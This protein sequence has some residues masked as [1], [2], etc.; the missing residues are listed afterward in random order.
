MLHYVTIRLLIN[1]SACAPKI[2]LIPRLLSGLDLSSQKKCEDF[3]GIFLMSHNQWTALDNIWTLTFAVIFVPRQELLS[4]LFSIFFFGYFSC[5]IKYT[6]R[7]CFSLSEQ[8][9]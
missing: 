9:I 2:K 8:R 4:G 6:G 5:M 1:D 3:L 7:F